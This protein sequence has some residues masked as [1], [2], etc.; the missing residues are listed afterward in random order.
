MTE[1]QG[2]E[3]LQAKLKKI[4]EFQRVMKPPM[5]KATALLHDEIA[6]YPPNPAHSTYRRTGTLGR[7]WTSKVDTH[8]QG[9]AGKVGNVTSY[10]QWVQ[11]NEKQVWFHR[12]AGWKTDKTVTDNQA[13]AIRRL[14]EDTVNKELRK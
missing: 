14:F 3:K 1:I 2:L 8:S 10:A 6:N 5:T 9:V 12:A 4:T 13:D 11:S 7:R